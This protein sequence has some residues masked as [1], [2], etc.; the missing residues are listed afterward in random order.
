MLSGRTFFGKVVFTK[1]AKYPTS[2]ND[3]SK[4]NKISEK[5]KKDFE[6]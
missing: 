5:F 4:K 2:L 3:I 1:T 6:G